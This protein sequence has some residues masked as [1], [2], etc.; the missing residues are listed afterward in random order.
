MGALAGHSA[1][2]ELLSHVE[3]GLVL[4]GPQPT[5]ALLVEEELAPRVGDDAQK[6]GQVAAV[7]DLWPWP[8]DIISGAA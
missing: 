6:G 3:F 7:E 8:L 5:L 4:Q 1:D 2:K